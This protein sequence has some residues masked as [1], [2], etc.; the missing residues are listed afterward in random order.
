MNAVIRRGVGS[1]ISVVAGTQSSDYKGAQVIEALSELS[2]ESTF[3]GIGGPQMR[4]FPNFTNYGTHNAIKDKPFFPYFN[5]DFDQRFYLFMPLLGSNI[6]NALFL[7]E[8]AKNGY[9]KNFQENGKD[10]D[11]VVTVGNELLSF[12]MLHKLARIYNRTNELKPIT[13]HID[14]THRDCHF[15]HTNYLDFFVHTLPLKMAS[16]Q[17]FTF[18]G[19]FIGKQVVFDA[20]S[21]LYKQ[22]PRFSQ[23]VNPE[24]IVLS[25]KI[26]VLATEEI[27]FHLRQEF[28]E[29]NFIPESSYLFFISPG[30]EDKE[31]A[32]NLKVAAKA[33]EV[34]VEKFTK[35]NRFSK[36]NFGVVISLPEGKE[37]LKS[38][39]QFFSK[40]DIMTRVIIGN[41]DDER[42]RAMAAC[43]VGAVANGDSVLE[44]TAF[45][46]PTVILD[47]SNFFH[48]YVNLMYN[49]HSSEL[50]W[51]AH[52]EVLPETTGRNFGEKV[53]EFW[54]N[55]FVA[56]K[57]R[58]KLAQ[59]C[60]RFLLGF[61]PKE[62][63][64][65]EMDVDATPEDQSFELY[66]NPDIVFRSF[67][68]RI[69]DNFRD[70]KD[71]GRFAHEK[72]LRRRAL[73]LGPDFV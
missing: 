12:R 38:H 69:H 30:S 27:A 16:P 64:P 15:D 37:S 31:I 22:T 39:T 19:Q 57:S 67:M 2:P 3:F 6:R 1:K 72:V 71:S 7:R 61:L 5:H 11:M 56:P 35:D 28:R 23:N 8:I 10:V 49:V 62:F 43:D 53:A 50:N 70:I 20:L 55:W 51:T 46:L 73:V 45:Q 48:S 14:A 60:N 47:N 25:S 26:N 9:W 24:T 52:G 4:S 17:N 59:R 58:Y 41:K 34:F 33:V 18:P 54:G 68:K 65:Y 36:K 63:T 40:S 42:Y 66:Y 21:F 44:C 29:R 13:V 32:D